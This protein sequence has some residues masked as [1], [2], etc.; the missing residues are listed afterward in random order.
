[1]QTKPKLVSTISAP[2]QRC[3]HC[4]TVGTQSEGAETAGFKRPKRVPNTNAPS[5]DHDDD[6]DGEI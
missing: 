4:T 2:R 3:E 6:D 1:M 5:D